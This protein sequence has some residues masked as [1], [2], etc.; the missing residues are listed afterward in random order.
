[1]VSTAKSKSKSGKN[2]NKV[3][4]TNYN[5]LVKLRDKHEIVELLLRYRKILKLLTA[6]VRPLIGFSG[7]VNAN[8]HNAVEENTTKNTYIYPQWNQLNTATGRLSTSNPSF[9]NL[10]RDDVKID[11]ET[12]VNIRKSFICKN[13]SAVIESTTLKNMR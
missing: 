7:K 11:R 8:K 12:T 9:Q 1:M 4:P 6:Y 13:S 2:N 5:V 10:P 3:Y